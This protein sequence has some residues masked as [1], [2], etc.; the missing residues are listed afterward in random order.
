MKP[1]VGSFLEYIA[2]AMALEPAR[3]SA[4]RLVQQRKALA[5]RLG[6][7]QLAE[8]RWDGEGGNMHVRP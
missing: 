7:D 2:T 1:R 3:F 5:S 6:R 4:L 8:Q